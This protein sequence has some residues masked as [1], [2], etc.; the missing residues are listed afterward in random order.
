MVILLFPYRVH[1]RP[2]RFGS[3]LHKVDVFGIAGRRMNVKFV[4][5]RTTSE[6]QCVCKNGMVENCNEC[7]ADD[8]VLLDLEVL[9]PGRMSP[10]L[11]DVITR[12]HK[13]GSISALTRIFQFASRGASL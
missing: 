6:R 4:E 2:S 12:D 9:H 1:H 8:E 11:S 13:S 7:P 3:D 10:P 5:R